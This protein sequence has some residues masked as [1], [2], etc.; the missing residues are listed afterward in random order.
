M[1]AWHIGRNARRA[2]PSASVG[3]PSPARWPAVIVVA[4]LVLLAGGTSRAQPGTPGA[5]PA[6]SPAAS[7]MATPAGPAN[8]IIV[9][10]VTI[11]ITDDGLDPVHFESAVGR[12][13]TI[14]VEN[15]TDRAQVFTLEAFDIE[16]DL[17]PGASETVEI[18][19][20]RLGNYPYSSTSEDGETFEGTM[21]VFI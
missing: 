1:R 20:P 13:V 7:P 21:T 8:V 15:R 12:D 4:L 19:L 18:A 11:G 3:I 9:G 10:S 6:A 2:H 5:S 16:L 17:A 14:T